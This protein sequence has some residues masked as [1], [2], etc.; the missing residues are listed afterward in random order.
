MLIFLLVLDMK[1][2]AQSFSEVL[3]GR[4]MPLLTAYEDWIVQ[5]AVQADDPS[6]G[7]QEYREVAQ[8]SLDEYRSTARLR[9][10]LAPW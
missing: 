8:Q 2:L 4:L 10:Y 6:A 1:T 5:Q 9:R 3:V 7:L